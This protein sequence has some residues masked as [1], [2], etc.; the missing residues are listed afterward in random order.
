V[1]TPATQRI[2]DAV[3][4]EFG[5]KVSVGAWACRKIAGSR[6]W[7]QH[8]WTEGEYEGNAADIF[9]S[10][11]TLDAVFTFI[12]HRFP[13]EVKTILWR[14]KNHWD[15]VHVDTWPTGYGTPPCGGGSLRVKHRDGKIGRTFDTG[16]DMPLSQDDLDKIAELLV[17]PAY[18]K[19]IEDAV[20]YRL[21]T[22]PV[23]G[24]QRGAQALLADAVKYS[25]Q[26]AT[27]P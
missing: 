7:S 27:K 12:V 2:V 26:A 24:Q 21:V 11:A 17:D 19:R 6:T 13:E 5:S 22:N 15:H 9:G 3:E 18:L 14:V 20:W 1:K 10:T 16:A 25:H 23:S 4:A 8:S